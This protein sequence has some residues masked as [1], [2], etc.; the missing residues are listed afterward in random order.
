M[1]QCLCPGPQV[2]TVDVIQADLLHPLF[3]RLQQAVDILVSSRHPGG[4]LDILISLCRCAEAADGLMAWFFGVAIISVK[5]CVL[6]ILLSWH[7]IN[8]GHAETLH[9]SCNM[10]ANMTAV[11]QS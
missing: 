2:T 7:I 5:Y 8:S 11:H 1:L 3:Y 4:Q 9:Q 6:A 10:L